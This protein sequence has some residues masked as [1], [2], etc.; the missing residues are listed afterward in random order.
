MAQL[1]LFILG[2]AIITLLARYNESNKLFWT[3]LTCLTIGFVGHKLINDAFGKKESKVKVE[4]VQPTQA[5][6]VTSG[7]LVYLLADSTLP[8]SVKA[9]SNPVSQVN[10]PI[11]DSFTLSYA[12]EVTQRLYPKTLPNPPNKVE[13][14][15]DS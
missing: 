9:T 8:T 5:L 2:V 11:N 14:V 3:L 10:V 6:A 13:I 4:Q 15:D 12:S 7:S 1:M